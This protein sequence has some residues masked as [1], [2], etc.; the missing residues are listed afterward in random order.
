MNAICELAR[1]S[2]KI[3]LEEGRRLQGEE[4]RGIRAACFVSLHEANG[5]LRGC[6]G[7]IEPVRDDLTLEI[8]ENAV[9]AGT[10]D[11]RFPPVLPEELDGLT[12]E[13][14]VLTPPEPVS[15]PLD[16]DAKRFGVVV[17]QGSRRGVLLPDLEGVDTVEQQLGITK[18][19]AGIYNEDP[20]ELWRFTVERHHEHV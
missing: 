2:L 14:S 6:I 11:P 3:W 16:L 5:E 1:R 4:P 19:K 15:G 7:T 10:R 18:R 9:S 8:I 12:I 20:V 13:V 17:R